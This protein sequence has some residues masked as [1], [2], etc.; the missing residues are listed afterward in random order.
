MKFL[1]NVAGYTRKDQIMNIKIMEELN[2]FSLNNKII[3]STPQCKYHVLRTE[4]W[5]IPKRNVGRPQ[6]SWR[7]QQTK[8]GLIHDDN[9][10]DDDDA[11]ILK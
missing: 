7:D 9:N 4:D 8:H 11:D 1:R 10:D 2:I 5:R 6:L 3:K